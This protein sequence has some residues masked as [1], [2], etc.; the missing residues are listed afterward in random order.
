RD[1]ANIIPWAAA[2]EAIALGNRARDSG[3]AVAPGCRPVII[4]PGLAFDDVVTVAEG[5]DVFADVIGL[6][7]T[8]KTIG[9]GNNAPDA[10]AA[11]PRGGCPTVGV[12]ERAFYQ[13]VSVAQGHVAADNENVVRVP[14]AHIVP[15]VATNEAIRVG[16][17]A[18]DSRRAAAPGDRPA[19]AV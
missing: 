7:A 1:V 3:A 9:V 19:V 11:A 15:G 13:V 14:A 17:G 18:A 12:P 5:N 8:D 2:N 10:G 16:N 6:A 4:V